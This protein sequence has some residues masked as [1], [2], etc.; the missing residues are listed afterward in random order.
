MPAECPGVRGLEMEY[1]VKADGPMAPHVASPVMPAVVLHVTPGGLEHGGGIGRMIG[2]MIDAWRQMPDRPQMRVLDTRGSGHILYSPW[3]LARC[4]LA[5]AAASRAR[6]LLHVHVAGRGSTLRKIVLVHFARLLRLPVVLHLHD[7]DYRDSLQRFPRMI[8]IAAASMFK[9][10]NQVVVLGPGDR[11][12]VRTELGV[13]ADRIT[14]IPNAV[15][16]PV[17]RRQGAESPRP[18]QLLFL[19]NP[20][21]RKG[22]HDL[23]AA[24][25]T[26]PLRGMDW[27]LIVAGGGNEIDTFSA[28]A[29]AAGLDDRVSFLGWVDRPRTTS[30]LNSTD[31]LALPSYAEGMAMS[32]LEGMA[33]GLCIVCTPVGS[34]RDVIDDEITGLLVKPGDTVA[35]A[36]ALTRAVNDAPLRSRLGSKAAQVFAGKFD[37]AD[38]PS[39]IRPVYAAAVGESFKRF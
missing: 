36:T 15:P 19:G 28:K 30:L 21:R 27:R 12:L 35:L 26:E 1:A 4:L 23:I 5:I 2:Y 31:I 13:C 33:Y 38:Y 24:L 7:Y 22:M 34:L 8:Q 14:V 10:S 18:V 16:A 17:Q 20:S 25:A 39:R 11:E 9:R 3:H 32:V 37:A 29:R 6:P